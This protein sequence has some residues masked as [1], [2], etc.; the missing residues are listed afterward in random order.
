MPTTDSEKNKPLND[1]RKS[2]FEREGLLSDKSAAVEG[3]TTRS[4]KV[5]REI[6]R[7]MSSPGE[8]NKLSSAEAE[9]PPRRVSKANS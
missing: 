8:T 2:V 3:Q 6:A 4:R 9:N 5:A 7:E 1:S